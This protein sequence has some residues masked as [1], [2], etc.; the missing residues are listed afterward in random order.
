MEQKSDWSLVRPTTVKEIFAAFNV[1]VFF[2][3]GRGVLIW[4]IHI[5]LARL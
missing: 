1:E 5:R 3:D 2:F 4:V